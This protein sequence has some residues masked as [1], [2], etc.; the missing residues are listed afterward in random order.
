MVDAAT[1][2]E[3]EGVE[4]KLR[5]VENEK[6]V[7]TEEEVME[8]K[9]TPKQVDNKKLSQ[10]VE[11]VEKT[12][13]HCLGPRYAILVKEGMGVKKRGEDKDKSTE[14]E[15]REEE[16]EDQA[17]EEKEEEQRVEGEDR[18]EEKESGTIYSYAITEGKNMKKGDTNKHATLFH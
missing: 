16:K 11:G 13:K 7:Q 2:T 18:E 12:P 6:S 3:E 1:Q 5:Q 14:E 15:G 4:E 8:L 9:R 10:T 17:S